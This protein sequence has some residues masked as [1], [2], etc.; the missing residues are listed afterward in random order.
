VR[1]LL[2]TCLTNL[3]Y[4]WILYYLVCLIFIILEALSNCIAVCHS[5]LGKLAPMLRHWAGGPIFIAPRGGKFIFQI[6]HWTQRIFKCL[7]TN[8]YNYQQQ[9]VLSILL[10]SNRAHLD[11]G[12]LS[13]LPPCFQ[14]ASSS[15]LSLMTLQSAAVVQNMAEREDRM[16]IIV[17]FNKQLSSSTSL[18]RSG[19]HM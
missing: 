18:C 9:T 12:N 4:I 19:I 10:S 5:S 7:T 8:Y 1:V 2:I 14:V 17:I 11:I 6:Y 3:H 13:V 15:L 16:W